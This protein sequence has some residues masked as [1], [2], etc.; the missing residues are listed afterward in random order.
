ML[1]LTNE[2]CMDLMSR[3][4]DNY[5]DLAIVDPPYGIGQ[6][7]AAGKRNNGFQKYIHQKKN[8][9]IQ[10]P[11]GEYFKELFRVSTHQIIWGANYFVNHLRVYPCYRHHSSRMYCDSRLVQ[12]HQVA[13][14]HHLILVH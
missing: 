7:K 9:D 11:D 2:D 8:W 4:D 10:A 13:T 5:F 6:H 12:Q 14:T 3:Y 1:K